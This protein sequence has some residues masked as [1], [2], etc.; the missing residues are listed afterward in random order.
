MSVLMPDFDSAVTVF[1][2]SETTHTC[3]YA[4]TMSVIVLV[5]MTHTNTHKFVKFLT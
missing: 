4:K 1:T 2:I 5:T 3:M